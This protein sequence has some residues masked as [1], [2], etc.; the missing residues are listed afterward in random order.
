MSVEKVN[1][2]TVTNFAIGKW[3]NIRTALFLLSALVVYFIRT[4]LYTNLAERLD[5][6]YRRLH[7]NYFKFLNQEDNNDDETVESS[8]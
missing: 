6:F 7:E 8:I 4:R 1:S 5:E 3:T 2:T